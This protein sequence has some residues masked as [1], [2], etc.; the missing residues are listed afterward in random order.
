M[1]SNAISQE[2]VDILEEEPIESTRCKKKGPKTRKGRKFVFECSDSE[3]STI[4][5]TTMKRHKENHN[6]IEKFKCEHCSFSAR[7]RAQVTYHS[8]RYHCNPPSV[9]L[10]V[11]C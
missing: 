7:M 10:E 1:E 9:P 2:V 11:S 6:Q 4:Y 8:N 5:W 3:F